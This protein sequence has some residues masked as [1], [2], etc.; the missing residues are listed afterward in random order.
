MKIGI[1]TPMAEEKKALTAALKDAETVAFSDLEVLVGQYNGQDVFLAESGIGKVAAATATT[2]LTQVFDVDLV[3]N[4]G[5]AGALQEGLSI[6]DLV[7]GSELA[8]FDADVTAFGYD[9]GQLPAQPAR[10]QAD[11]SLVSAFEKLT[12]AKKGLIVTGDTFVQQSMKEKILQNF[13]DAQLAEMEGAAVAQVATRFK[14]PFIVLRGVS[15]QAD[16][17]SNIDFDEYVVQA[18]QKSAEL[19]LA[20]LDTINE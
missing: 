8:Y 14:K 11:S 13:T 6:G 7:I 15:D 16:G 3:I 17:E 4:T 20:Y 18:G 10:F 19:L 5:S 12:D 1:I 2:I 9:Y